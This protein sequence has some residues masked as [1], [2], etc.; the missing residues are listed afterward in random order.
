MGVVSSPVFLLSLREVRW[1]LVSAKSLPAYHIIALY[2][3]LYYC[4]YYVELK[5]IVSYYFFT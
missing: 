2:Y 1:V 3:V 4:I 5:L